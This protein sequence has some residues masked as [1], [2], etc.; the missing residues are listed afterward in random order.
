MNF[1]A[2]ELVNSGVLKTPAIIDAFDRID[3]KDFIPDE[4]KEQAYLNIPLSINCG[5]TISQP[6]TVAF[7]LELLQPEPGNKI[8]EIGYGSGWQTALLANI[9]GRG[10]AD[11]KVFAMEIVPE[12]CDF[13]RKNIV[14]Y[15]FIKTKTVEL[16]CFSAL[17]GLPEQAPFD[18]IISAASAKEIPSSWKEQ[19]KIGGRMV[20]PLGNSVFLF[21]KKGET[22]FEES[23]YPGFAFVPFVDK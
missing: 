20:A 12:L 13:G 3:R 8:L 15:D 22:S 1:L 7:M 2:K 11:G 17:K 14:K 4:I 10:G 19:L 16:F 23:E 18:R 9:A 5:Q 6:W 21:I